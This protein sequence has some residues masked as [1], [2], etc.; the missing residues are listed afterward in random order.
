MPA[1]LPAKL[2]SE[3]IPPLTA[4]HF[5]VAVVLLAAPFAASL[6]AWRCRSL[7]DRLCAIVSVLLALFGIY[8]FIRF[9]A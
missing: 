5:V 1:L 4:A 9:M 7:P 2:G 3:F 6:F 8:A